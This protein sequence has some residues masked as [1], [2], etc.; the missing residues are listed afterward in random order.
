[1]NSEEDLICPNCSHNYTIENPPRMLPSCGHTY[2]SMCIG[3][4]ISRKKLTS[5]FKI[6]CP[7]DKITIDLASKNP[8]SLPKNIA[9]LKMIN[10]RKI[11]YY[12]QRMFSKLDL[13]DEVVGNASK[14]CSKYS[15]HEKLN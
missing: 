11:E 7:E 15:D 6:T 8:S 1:M 5:K 14:Y 10:K 12:Y 2:C 4:L 3:I 9:L 13:P